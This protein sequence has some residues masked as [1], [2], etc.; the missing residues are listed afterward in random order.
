MSYKG[1]VVDHDS[2]IDAEINKRVLQGYE[3]VQV[4]A[5]TNAGSTSRYTILMRTSK[6]NDATHELANTLRKTVENIKSDPSNPVN[7]ALTDILLKFRDGLNK[8]A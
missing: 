7:V 3:L 8:T 2:Q 4:L 1:F 5:R 6:E